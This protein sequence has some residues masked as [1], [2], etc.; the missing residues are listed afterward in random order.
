[1]QLFFQVQQSIDQIH[2]PL[3]REI[4]N[5]K[6][7]VGIFTRRILPLDVDRGLSPFLKLSFSVFKNVLIFCNSSLR[8]RTLDK[9]IKFFD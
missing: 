8:N 1:M 2:Q 7:N 6:N 5:S 9:I 4:N 3:K